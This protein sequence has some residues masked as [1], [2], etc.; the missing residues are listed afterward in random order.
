MI[1]NSG[2]S[3]IETTLCLIPMVGLFLVLSCCIV[4]PALLYWNEHFVYENSLCLLHINKVPSQCE[5]EFKKNVSSILP[6]SLVHF[7]AKILS[8]EATTEAH[9]IG[10]G[11]QIYK[12]HETVKLE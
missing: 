2:Q 3:C 12:L 5:K 4:W 11:Q 8:S 7:K 6:K 10:I 1:N 9:F